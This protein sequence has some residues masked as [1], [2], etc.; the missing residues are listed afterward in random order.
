MSEHLAV[1]GGVAGAGAGIAHGEVLPVGTDVGGLKLLAETGCGVAGV[2]IGA[3]DG[4]QPIRVAQ[5]HQ[6][7]LALLSH[8][9][10]AA[11]PAE[12]FQRRF[13]VASEGALS[14][15]FVKR[16]LQR[17]TQGVQHIEAGG[18]GHGE[19]FRVGLLPHL[20]PVPGDGIALGFEVANGAPRR[21]FDGKAEIDGIRHAQS[22]VPF[23]RPQ[24][25]ATN[26]R[27]VSCSVSASAS[28]SG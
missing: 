20:P 3:K 12:L 24:L 5:L 23:S 2:H 21:Q 17:A 27:R 6:F 14:H 8:H 26:R 4:F 1:Q 22:A 9:H 28:S 18:F 19:G 16:A 15:A 11:P 7:R 25:S 13:H 10:L